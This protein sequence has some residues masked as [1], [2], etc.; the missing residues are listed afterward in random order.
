M[1]NIAEDIEVL[2]VCL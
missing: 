2:P 1:K